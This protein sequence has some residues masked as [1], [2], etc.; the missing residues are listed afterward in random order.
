VELPYDSFVNDVE[1]PSIVVITHDSQVCRHLQT[2]PTAHARY[3]HTSL[4]TPQHNTQQALQLYLVLYAVA[5]P[6]FGACV[7]EGGD[8]NPPQVSL[9]VLHGLPQ[10]V[11]RGRPRS[12]TFT[13]HQVCALMLRGSRCTSAFVP[14]STHHH[15]QRMS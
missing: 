14:R 9:D 1:D 7:L 8:P 2:S 13:V 15:L 3:T 12:F 11:P 4:T 10:S 5:W 6:D